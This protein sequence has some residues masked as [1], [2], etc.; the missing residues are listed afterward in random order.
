MSKRRARNNQVISA[1]NLAC[2]LLLATILLLSLTVYVVLSKRDGEAPTIECD[3]EALFLSA[4]EIE[5]VL[6]KDYRCLLKGITAVDNKD[7]DVTSKV[8]VYSTDVHGDDSY[9]VVN[10]RVLDSAGNVAKYRRLAYIKSPA[11]IHEIVLEKIADYAGTDVEQ[12]KELMGEEESESENNSANAD[13][14]VPVLLMETEVTLARNE[15]FNPAAY[16][17][18]LSDDMDSRE[19]LINHAHME[20]I[21]DSYTPGLYTVTFYVTDSDGNNSDSVTMNVTVE[22]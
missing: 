18:A 10:Y 16:V 4:S 22:E 14:G 8:I 19:Y 3:R 9:I 6:N 7:G 15:D 2:L 17:I 20:G 21:V 1:K 12:I 11:E 5:S 13:T